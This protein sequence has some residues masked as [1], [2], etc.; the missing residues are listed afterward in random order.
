[1]VPLFPPGEG[2]TL[3][4]CP[5]CFRAVTGS[6]CKGRAPPP[7]SRKA[8]KLPIQKTNYNKNEQKHFFFKL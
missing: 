7:A 1:M 6:I 8:K 5:P 3:L 2:A 4:K